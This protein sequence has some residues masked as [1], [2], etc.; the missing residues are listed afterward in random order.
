[1]QKYVMTL[2]RAISCVDDFVLDSEVLTKVDYLVR[3]NYF[4]SWWTHL[5]ISEYPIATYYSAAFNS[6]TLPLPFR[7]HFASRLGLHPAGSL[8][9]RTLSDEASSDAA[10]CAVDFH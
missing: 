4:R 5:D 2:I 9:S 6:V 7:I 10:S 8:V 3:T 1:M